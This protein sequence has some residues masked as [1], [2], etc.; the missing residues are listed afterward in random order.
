M[1]LEKNSI[2]SLTA[3]IFVLMSFTLS[4]LTSPSFYQL[5]IIIFILAVVIIGLFELREY[6]N[7][8]LY[9]AIVT[10]FLVVM[11]IVSYIQALSLS[12][13]TLLY[14]ETGLLTLALIGVLI[15]SLRRWERF[16][17]ALKPYDEALSI[18]P[19]DTTALNNKGVELTG[20]KRY[21][22]A[23]ECFNKTIEIEP[24]DAAAWHNKGVV[25]KKQKK[26]EKAKKYYNKALELDPKFELAKKSGKII[27][28]N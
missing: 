25:L 28:E 23:I 8:N 22:K 1:R 20:Q 19:N 21:G 26:R 7:K 11:W 10:V 4:Y 16:E 6:Y 3:A 13:D 27:L 14:I 5:P 17:N 18:N 24:Q 12:V 15:D 2:G 9:L